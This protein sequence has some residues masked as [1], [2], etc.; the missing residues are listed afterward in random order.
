MNSIVATLMIA[1]AIAFVAGVLVAIV[2]VIAEWWEAGR[3]GR[4]MRR[5]NM[6]PY[7]GIEPSK[8]WPRS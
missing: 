5:A 2:V 7:R 4:A 1:M 3:N 6:V 8:P